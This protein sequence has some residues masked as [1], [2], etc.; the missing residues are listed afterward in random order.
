MKRILIFTL[1]MVFMA[2]IVYASDG[3]Y[4]YNDND[5]QQN[6][7]Q[8]QKQGQDQKTTVDIDSHDINREFVRAPITSLPEHSRFTVRPTKDSSFRDIQEL[9]NIYDRF[10]EGT[11]DKLKEGGKVKVHYQMLNDEDQIKR[12]EPIKGERWIRLVI[13]KP[14]KGAKIV[15]MLDGEAKDGDTNSF[16]VLGAI[17]QAAYEDGSNIV[18][19]TNQ[20]THRQVNASSK[21]FGGNIAGAAVNTDG[22]V[23][24]VTGGGM[25]FSFSKA[26]TDDKPWFHAYAAVE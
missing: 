14:V 22:T 6:Q 5:Q 13:G 12:A 25:G 21:G 1:V 20:D 3:A 4:N 11:I 10:N 19:I 17:L 8:Q 26:L 23:S 15:A 16:Q 7:E 24:G 18:Y 9:L 2:S